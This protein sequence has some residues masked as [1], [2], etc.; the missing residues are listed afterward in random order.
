MWL[1]QVD[2]KVLIEDFASISSLLLSITMSYEL[3]EWKGDG[4]LV[5]ENIITLYALSQNRCIWLVAGV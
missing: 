3:Y 1:V 5:G 2:L 4:K